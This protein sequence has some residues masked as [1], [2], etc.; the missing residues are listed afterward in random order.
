MD[1]RFRTGMA[2]EVQ[3]ALPCGRH[4]LRSALVFGPQPMHFALGFLRGAQGIE[5]HEAR[6]RGIVDGTGFRFQRADAGF[7]VGGGVWER[8]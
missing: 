8:G 3:S 1:W 4:G 6:Q 7:L 2:G 5:R